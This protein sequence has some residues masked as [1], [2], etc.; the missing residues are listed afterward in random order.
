MMDERIIPFGLG[1]L[2]V[3]L[4]TIA[5]FM[6]YVDEASAGAFTGVAE[7]TILQSEYGWINIVF[8]GGWIVGLLVNL[9]DPHRVWWPLVVGGLTVASA[10][11]AATDEE[12]RTLCP[13]GATRVTDA[14]S[15]AEPGVGVY[16][17][18]AGGAALVMSGFFFRKLP[19]KRKAGQPIVADPMAVTRE[20]PHCK[21]AIRP[22][23][24]VCPH[25][26]RESAPWKLHNNIWWRDEAGSW[27]WLD[28]AASP[29][30]WRHF[31][32][33]PGRTEGATS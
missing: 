24:S 17:L 13:L 11:W 23:A 25:C 3:T 29:G 1:F 9:R 21:S 14:C 6:P 12:Q 15:V 5:L 2:G 18:G 7:N 27:F 26:Q 4:A 31:D 19:E 32:A 16:M 28:P 33:E 10:V 20:C 30:T 22:D 8:I